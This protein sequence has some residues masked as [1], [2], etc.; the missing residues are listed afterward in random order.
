MSIPGAEERSAHQAARRAGYGYCL[1]RL[2]AGGTGPREQKS[3]MAIWLADLRS[4]LGNILRAEVTDELLGPIRMGEL[5]EEAIHRLSHDPMRYFGHDHGGGGAGFDHRSPE[6]AAGTYPRSRAGCRR[7]YIDRDFSKPPRS[8]AG[9]ESAEQRSLCADVGRPRVVVG[10]ADRREEVGLMDLIK[11]CADYCRDHPGRVVFPDSL[12][13]RAIAAAARLVA[14]G[15]AHP[16]LLG[17]PFAIRGLCRDKQLSLRQVPVID[18]QR[19]LLREHYADLLLPK[20]AERGMKREEVLAHLDDPLWYGAMMVAAGDADY[21][22]AGSL[23][24]TSNVLQAALNAVAWRRGT[25][26]FPAFFS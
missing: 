24:S 1:C 2:G 23:S 9:T 14:E 25:R 7:V 3:V 4:T 15:L 21:C 19:S 18:P 20:V 11:T 12:D 26:R 22:V 8:D 5:D 16:V 6:H 10:A 13:E 17:N